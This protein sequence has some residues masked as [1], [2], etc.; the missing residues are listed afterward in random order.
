MIFCGVK[1]DSIVQYKMSDLI[2]GGIVSLVHADYRCAQRGR[3]RARSEMRLL[4]DNIPCS[5]ILIIGFVA[6]GIPIYYLTQAENTRGQSRVTCKYQ[7]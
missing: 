4:Y 2:L 1:T 3:C 5:S 7:L 6:T